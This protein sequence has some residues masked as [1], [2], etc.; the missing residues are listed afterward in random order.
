MYFC[1]CQAKP[2]KQ[3]IPQIHEKSIDVNGGGWGK[4]GG[5]FSFETV[6]ESLMAL[7]SKTN[8]E[9]SLMALTCV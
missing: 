6:H 1:I 5:F 4:V 3:N 2:K 9:P 8:A 7:D